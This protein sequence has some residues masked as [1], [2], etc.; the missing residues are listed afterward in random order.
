MILNTG[1]GISP[2]CC[3][4]FFYSRSELISVQPSSSSQVACTSPSLN[5]VATWSHHV[6]WFV[7][8]QRHSS[9]STS[10]Y[11]FTPTDFPPHLSIAKHRIDEE[12]TRLYY[13]PSSNCNFD[14]YL[15]AFPCF[16][17]HLSH[18]NRRIR[19]TIFIFLVAQSTDWRFVC[20]SRLNCRTPVSNWELASRWASHAEGGNVS[21]APVAY[22]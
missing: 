5:V 12:R 18:T 19:G 17:A 8:I 10:T 11:H 2:A 3:I 15:S 4:I 7:I 16:Y 1:A 20:S 22:S 21:Q 13:Q 6:I 14:S 9:K